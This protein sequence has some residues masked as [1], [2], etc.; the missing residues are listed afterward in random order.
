MH[1]TLYPTAFCAFF[2]NPFPRIP[3]TPPFSPPA[4]RPLLIVL[5][6]PSGAGKSTLCDK[7][8]AEFPDIV[9]SVSCTTRA[10]RGAEVDGEDYYFLDRPTFEA[11]I[12]KGEFLEHAEVHGNHYGTLR[13]TVESAFAEGLSIVMDIDVAG[14]AQVRSY[15]RALPEGNPLREGFLDIFITAPSME[16]LRR[17]LVARAEDAPDVIE[18]RLAN[19]ATEMASAHLYS[20]RIVNDRLDVAYAELRD[21]ILAARER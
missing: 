8:L 7:L 13:T 5:S 14:A 15:V 21:L 12:A 2:L 4:M 3:S 9:Y 6:A 16:E 1:K 18:R 10:P 20:A 17:R 11:R 19:A